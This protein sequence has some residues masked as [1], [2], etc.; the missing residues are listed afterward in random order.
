MASQRSITTERL[1]AVVG[2]F[3]LLGGCSTRSSSSGEVSSKS[4]SP[5]ALNSGRFAPAGVKS[6]A[7]L[8][9]AEICGLAD[10]KLVGKEFGFDFGGFEPRYE[11]G[12][13]GAKCGFDATSDGFQGDQL[14]VSWY[15]GPPQ[16]PDPEPSD[17]LTRSQSL[18]NGLAVSVSVNGELVNATMLLK[19]RLIRVE[20]FTDNDQRRA[21]IVKHVLALLSVV[22]SRVAALRPSPQPNF[23]ARVPD[24]FVFSPAQLCSLLRDKTVTAL[25]RA[26]LNLAAASRDAFDI[27]LVRSDLLWCT[28]GRSKLELLVTSWKTSNYA[29]QPIRGLP[30]I[31]SIGLLNSEDPRSEQARL[32]VAAS[33][34]VDGGIE[35]RVITLI[36]EGTAYNAVSR[37]ILRS[38]MDH[39]IGELNR[40]LPQPLVYKLEDSGR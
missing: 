28:K 32:E 2:M 38:E 18:V 35:E 16:T 27:S 15:V 25:G 5:W 14:E 40:R 39:I 9:V 12:A 31:S 17:L 22:H 1:W 26:P 30:S 4:R 20:T 7:S 36:A 29:D 11:I 10:G 24:V 34:I 33:R 3:V 8:S 37:E 13:R 6:F 21:Q 23:G 19:D